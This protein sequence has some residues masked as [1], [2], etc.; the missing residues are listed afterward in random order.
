MKIKDLIQYPLNKTQY[1]PIVFKKKQ[2]VL[3]HT[4]SGPDAKNVINYW[5]NT[6]ERVATPFIIDGNGNIYQCFSSA[7]WA[8][9]LGTHNKNNVQLN[10]QSI[11]IE[12]C[13][14]GA[15]TEKGGRYYSAFNKEVP[16]EEVI[17]YG[18]NWRGHRYFHKYK[19]EQLDS[20]KILIEYLCKKYEIPS[21]Y[22]SDMWELNNRALDGTPGIWTHVSFRPDKSDCHPQL[23]LINLLKSLSEVRL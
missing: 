16:K 9:H 23:S 13:N 4:V 17:D 20:L 19:D 1:Y 7:H 8:H 12:I 15:L 2:I 18:I 10:Q 5:G 14:W 11:G 3:H 22:Q 6:I 21:T